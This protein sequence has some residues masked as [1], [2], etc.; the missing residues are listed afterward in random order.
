MHIAI[1]YTPA[2]EQQ[3]GIGRHTRE[4]VAALLRAE[5]GHEFVFLGPRPE[6]PPEL[7]AFVGP[8]VRWAA[9]PV[10]ARAAAVLWHRLKV[11]VPVT[12]LTG[13]VDLFHGLDFTLPPLGS[14]RG[15]VTV[16]DLSF[17]RFPAYGDP[18]L[19]RYLMKAVPDAVHRS[20]LVLAVSENT[21]EEVILHLGKEPED[22]AVVYGGVS[23]AFRPQP[24]EQIQR[25]RER[26]GL[27]EA[28]LLTVGRIE[29]RKNLPGLFRAYRLLRERHAVDVPLVIGGGKGW[30]VAGIMRA[31]E[32]ADLNGH[33]RFLDHVP[34]P[35]LP[36][37]LGG[38]SLFVYP[39]F[40][41]G[42]GLPPL[43]AMACGTPVVASDAPCLPEVL[44]D[45]A[46]FASPHDD[47]ALA[48]AMAR[49]LT[50]PGL[51]GELR[52]R[53]LQQAARFSWDASARQLLGAYQQVFSRPAAG[54]VP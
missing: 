5:T 35:D 19:I 44:G 4:L 54:S 28:Y 32:Q 52:D 12:W 50:D 43:E 48:A 33:V 8:R 53:G 29:P 45:A 3:A 23:T 37:L 7:T 10:P 39:S 38:A 18:G 41:E 24:S 20:A 22:V 2:I 21:R 27:P 6:A 17:L 30:Q 46:L 51:R 16:H 49:A 15:A 42:F 47:D 14:A 13:D 26:Y 25:V 31:L 36:A 40:Y 34:D 9:L 11:P 1:D